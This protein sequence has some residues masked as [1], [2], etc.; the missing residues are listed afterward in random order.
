[1]PNYY[2]IR[3]PTCLATNSVAKNS[4]VNKIINCNKCK[5]KFE[6]KDALPMKTENHPESVSSKV[7]NEIYQL[8]NLSISNWV[9]SVIAII[10]I[11]IVV[12]LYD[13]D[14]LGSDF[15]VFYIF[16]FIITILINTLCRWYW[17]DILSVSILGFVLFELIGVVRY[18]DAS[19]NAMQ[20]FSG[21]QAT[22]FI[23]GVLFFVRAKHFNNTGNSSGDSSSC[24]GGSCGGGC[25]GCGG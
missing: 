11:I 10:L 23:G 5:R 24:S 14:M 22:M 8:E 17:K 13:I 19:N 1:M 12:R 3:C 6:F 18:I 2:S 16:T 21:L 4:S 25:G 9:I 7:L 15:I 20:N